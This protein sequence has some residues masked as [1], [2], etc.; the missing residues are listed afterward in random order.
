MIPADLQR[1]VALGSLDLSPDGELVVYTRRSTVRGADRTALWLV[2]Y[3]GGRPWRLVGAT[4]GLGDPRF[5]PDGRHVAYLAG[6]LHVVEVATGRSVLVTRFRRGVSGHAW[7]PDG[8]ALVVVA[9]DERTPR[10]VGEDRRDGPTAR[11][12]E[13]ADWRR[14]GVGLALHPAHLHVVELGG[15]APRRL[16]TGTWSAT[17]PCVDADGRAV[18]FLAD[19]DPFADLRCGASAHRVPWGGGEVVALPGAPL[20]A[21]ALAADVAGG[22]LVL[23][24]LGGAAEP[25]TP[26]AIFHVAGDDAVRCLSATTDRWLGC[27]A[28]GSD[29]FD[30]T[31]T[32]RF[33][34]RHTSLATDGLAIPVRVADGGI[35]ELV[36]R[37]LEPVCYAIVERLGRVAA[38]LSTGRE[39]PEIVALDAAVPRRLTTEGRWI[40]TYPRPATTTIDVGSTRAFVVEPPSAVG[41]PRATI[42]ALHGGPTDQWNPLA[43]LEAL[44][45]A[46][47]GYRVVL[48]NICG[49]IERGAAGVAALRGRWGGPDAADVHALCDALVA[50]GEVDPTRLGLLGLSYGGFLV[51]WLVG[52]SDRF[53]A[54]VSENGVANQVSAWANSDTGAVY[55]DAYGLGAATD[56]AGVALLWQQSPLR[57]VARIRTPLLVLQGEDDLI[58]PPS[59]SEQLF[60]A[61]RR[62]GR[63]ATYVTYPECAH[64]YQGTGRPDRRIDRHER[65]LAFFAQRMPA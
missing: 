2:P 18:A 7:H 20:G 50:A 9:E 37:E 4:A 39:A 30:W 32:T 34:G 47:A 60:V 52:T 48:P 5:S 26:T 25:N 8:G 28:A 51:N 15:A 54:A 19:R 61:L 58:C 62:L 29:L 11:V 65:V 12:L 46:H 31:A 53:A 33:D 63:D 64:V 16:T 59:D 21:S 24:P 17:A 1:Q 55:C 27:G 42:I 57:N 10:L 35:V 41:P 40:A 3:A 44:L 22:I 14:D 36:A 38:V 45:L 43:P 56:P 23:A 49:G 6:Q 13:R